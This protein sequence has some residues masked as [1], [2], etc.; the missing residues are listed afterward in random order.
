[1]LMSTVLLSATNSKKDKDHFTLE[2]K[3]IAEKHVNYQVFEVGKDTVL[4][5]QNNNI[6]Y[7]AYSIT[8]DVGKSYIVQFTNAAGKVKT[9]GIIAQKYGYFV[10]DVD[11][12]TDK[13]ASLTYN[14]W[15]Y[16]LKPVEKEQ[17]CYEPKRSNYKNN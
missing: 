12:R 8:V 7:N 14:G 5:A 3:F 13:S 15:S 11:F 9:L 6:S 1:M 4:V 2:G 17:L 16:S 10:L